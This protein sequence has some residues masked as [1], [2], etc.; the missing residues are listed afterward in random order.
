MGEQAGID[1]YRMGKESMQAQLGDYK[2]DALSGLDQVTTALKN[3]QIARE[4]EV[5]AEKAGKKKARN[6]AAEKISNYIESQ[7]E[8][9]KNLG[10][11]SFAQCQR[12]VGALRDQMFRAIDAGDQD[13]IG[14]LN[15]QLNQIKERHAS[16]AE[17]LNYLTDSYES[18]LIS[19]DAM[20]DED[21]RVHGEWATNPTKR[22]WYDENNVLHYQWESTTK[23]D[24]DGNP[25]TESYSL[26][27]LNDMIV[28]KDSVNG[29]KLMDQVQ[30]WKEMR[31][32]D[33]NSTPSDAQILK[34]MKSIIP[35]DP[36]MLRDWLHGN[37]ADAD[38]LDVEQY[39]H[40]LL[41][42]ENN[43]VLALEQVAG[44]EFFAGI[45]NTSG[46]DGIKDDVVDVWDLT[47]DDRLEIIRKIMDVEDPE[48]S[49]EIIS[50]IYADIS[51]NNVLGIEYQEMDDGT[52][53]GNKDYRGEEETTIMGN[54]QNA[55]GLTL[56]ERTEKLNNLKSLSDP[57]SEIW[58][59]L[60]G[61]NK[62]EIAKKLGFKDLNAQILVDGKMTSIRTFIP[63]AGKAATQGQSGGTDRSK[64]ES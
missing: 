56:N 6:A 45:Q 26:E 39:L 49:H 63:D 14:K 5:M 16:D 37:P 54:K 19:A 43:S 36:K 11:E 21:Q 33:P 29:E 40:D 42:V 8:M 18:K 48:K 3:R 53:V 52:H 31:E 2:G 34:Q 57:K 58:K 30:K 62:L 1:W 55:D 61:L 7:S 51:K 25:V 4:K 9:H 24:D 17:N 15:M 35:D 59:D 47:E 12:E 32:E 23:F 20:T 22:V 13:M 10:P 41:S 28:L 60:E 44:K 46:P 64:G 27:R 50:E 38:G